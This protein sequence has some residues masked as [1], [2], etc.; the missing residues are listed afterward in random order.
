MAGSIH[1]ASSE[2]VKSVLDP[3]MDL[4]P[5][6]PSGGQPAL[7]RGNKVHH[8]FFSPRSATTGPHSRRSGY[9]GHQP[10][11]GRFAKLSV[12]QFPRQLAL[13]QDKDATT[14]ADQLGQF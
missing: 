4:S 11:Q 8:S 3:T 14:K 13:T 1:S 5:L 9:T 6:R 2:T 10:H 12:R 7:R